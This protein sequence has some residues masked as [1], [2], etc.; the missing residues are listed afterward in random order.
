MADDE[1]SKQR[2][3]EIELKFM[4]EM[5]VEQTWEVPASPKQDGGPLT[6]SLRM[7]HLRITDGEGRYIV[8]SPDQAEL[9]S[10]RLSDVYCWLR[11]D[12]PES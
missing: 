5:P 8:V 3:R 12:A 10:S 11:Y 2:L 1:T 6:V 4:A 7:P 9:L